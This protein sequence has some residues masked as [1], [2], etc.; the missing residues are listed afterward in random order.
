MKNSKR[1]KNIK[2][3]DEKSYCNKIVTY[4]LI[5]IILITL[6]ILSMFIK[7]IQIFKNNQIKQPQ[8]KEEVQSKV[9]RFIG[10]YKEII[11]NNNDIQLVE[12]LNSIKESE[13]IDQVISNTDNSVEIELDNFYIVIDKKMLIINLIEADSETHFFYEF[14]E[15]RD[16]KIRILIR[17]KNKNI[18][19][20]RVEFSD[21]DILY[22]NDRNEICIDYELEDGI[23]YN[24]KIIASDGTEKNELINLKIPNTPEIEDIIIGMPT[25]TFTGTKEEKLQKLQIKYDLR[26][27]FVNYYSF[28]EGKV[29]NLYEQPIYI[30]SI[31]VLARTVNPKCIGFY[32]EEKKELQ[33]VT[34]NVLLPES[35]DE[36]ESTYALYENSCEFYVDESMWNK[37]IEIAFKNNWTGNGTRYLYLSCYDNENKLIESI[38]LGGVTLL[39]CIEP[40]I[41]YSKIPENTKK[42]VLGLD[43]GLYVHEIHPIL[44]MPIIQLVEGF[45][46]LSNGVFKNIIEIKY[47]SLENADN[48]YSE[49]D[50]KT[51]NKY[52]EPIYTTATMIKAKSVYS[53][54][55]TI[56]SKESKFLY[57]DIPS[58]LSPNCYDGDRTTYT[59]YRDSCEFYVDESMWNKEIEIAFKN[60]FTGNGTRYL[61]LSCYDNE[62]K[63]IESINLGGV[64]LLPCIEP[65]IAYSKIPE[66]TKKLVL[67]LDTGLYVHEISIK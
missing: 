13:N 19:L 46:L 49:D 16:N 61:Y 11:K 18:G 23:D 36:D 14:S 47:D 55:N 33:K 21:E 51:W 43:T 59:L 63:L 7:R 9:E 53:K 66:N 35:Y 64:T 8:N 10:D 6:I 3:K 28:D 26:E 5:I 45:P 4:I 57:S 12:Y 34:N 32:I 17:I 25:I 42:L 37:E 62:N 31:Y 22:I 15:I 2:T 40:K 65:K 58:V 52:T 29:W 27:D 20:Q 48:Y 54:N 56:N 30:K 41:A 38:N 60:N 67:G 50:G 1:C 44:A 39:P 24:F